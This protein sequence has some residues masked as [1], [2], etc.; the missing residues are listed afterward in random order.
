MKGW[1]WDRFVG[2]AQALKF[3]RRDLPKFDAMLRH[4]RRRQAAVQ[5][6][7]HL[8]LF[9]KWLARTFET[10]YTFE[11]APVLFR[12]M[13]I[14]APELNIVRFEAAL[15]ETRGVVGLSQRRRHGRMVGEHEGLTHVD[16]LG[17]VPT[18]LVD[19]LALPVCDLLALDLEG[20]ELYALRGARGT[21][22]RCR[23]VVSV[24][25]NEN[26]GH[27]GISREAVVLELVDQ[28]YRYV[29]SQASDQVFLPA[30]WTI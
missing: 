14:N 6:G 4:C 7:G 30:D 27:Y 10:V 18:L 20:Y 25:I 12:A 15:G 13:A 11:P 19:D 5:A 29:E 21:L 17:T 24:E 1:Q 16:G 3:N 2:S 26:C 8:G 22:R 9:P 28:G 23:P